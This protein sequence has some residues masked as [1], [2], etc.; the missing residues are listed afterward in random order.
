MSKIIVQSVT[1]CVFV[2]VMVLYTVLR[3][4]SFP[5][6]NIDFFVQQYFLQI[7]SPHQPLNVALA[8]T[9]LPAIL[10]LIPKKLNHEKI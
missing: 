1:Q 7:K 8:Y 4:Y 6:P 10:R 2:L 5:I 9:K 3:I